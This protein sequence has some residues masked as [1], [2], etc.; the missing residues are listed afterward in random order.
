MSNLEFL[1]E[2]E[3]K[4]TVVG[5]DKVTGFSCVFSS[6]NKKFYNAEDKAVKVYSGDEDN[7]MDFFVGEEEFETRFCNFKLQDL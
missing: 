3:D 6:V 5:V 4:N 2:N 1:K 7:E